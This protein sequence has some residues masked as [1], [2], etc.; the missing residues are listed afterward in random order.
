MFKEGEERENTLPFNPLLAGWKYKG[1]NC[2]D[3][4]FLKDGVTMYAGKRMVFKK[5]QDV[6]KV[7]ALPSNQLQF[8]IKQHGINGNA[9]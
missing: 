6:V 9:N 7:C 1:A 3:V 5:G 4:L 8:L 2:C